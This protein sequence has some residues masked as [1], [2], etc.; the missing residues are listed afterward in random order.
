MVP[1]GVGVSW[2]ATARARSPP[3]SAPSAGRA[4]PAAPAVAMRRRRLSE[5]PSRTSTVAREGRPDWFFAALIG[6][7]FP[8]LSDPG[9][10]RAP[11]LE[12]DPLRKLDRLP[13]AAE[14]D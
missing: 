14:L 5:L 11:H 10:R 7:S 6:C 3:G 8:V 12:I 4:T 1:P 2:T 9:P 13:P